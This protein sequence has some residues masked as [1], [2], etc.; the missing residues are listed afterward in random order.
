MHRPFLR[1]PTRSAFTIVELLVSMAVI[2]L[3][4][5]L[6]MPAVQ[7]ARESARRVACKNNLHQIGMALENRTGTLGHFPDAAIVF[8]ELLP[9]LDQSAIWH[10]ILNDVYS[11]GSV[12]RPSLATFRCPSDPV[13]PYPDTL[14]YAANFGTGNQVDGL[15]GF[16][17]TTDDAFAVGWPG[18]SASSLSLTRHQDIT[19]GLSQTVAI[20]E[21]LP[22]SVE[23]YAP[24]GSPVSDFR[25]VIWV[26]SPPL[27]RP[28][29]FTQFRSQC[30]ALRVAQ[31]GFNFSSA[32]RGWNWST[33]SGIVPMALY[34]HVLNP[35]MPSCFNSGPTYGAYSAGSLHTGGAHVLFGDGHVEFMSDQVDAKV[36]HDIGTRAGSRTSY[37]VPRFFERSQGMY[38]SVYLSCLIMAMASTAQAFDNITLPSNPFDLTCTGVNY[39]TTIVANS[40][41]AE[42]FNVAFERKLPDGTWSGVASGGKMITANRTYNV[43]VTLP[44]LPAGTVYNTC[45]AKILRNGMVLSTSIISGVLRGP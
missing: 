4:C 28:N 29:E 14:C 5:A 2:G 12:A 19:D 23:A 41:T 10:N 9:E 21:M 8:R 37:Q 27:A 1:S 43:D 22:S 40:N 6:L 13:A 7:M 38:R 32:T 31:T 16:F 45:Q 42:Q 36:W 20:A 44:N 30:A 25:R 3:L 17:V 34:H 33:T 35:N 24:P 26:I 39:T 18:T 11:N 15:N